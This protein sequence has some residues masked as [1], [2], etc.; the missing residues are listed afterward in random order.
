MITFFCRFTLVSRALTRLC[1]NYGSGTQGTI[2][3]NTEPTAVAPDL[4]GYV[5]YQRVGHTGVAFSIR[6]YRARFC[7]NDKNGKRHTQQAESGAIRFLKIAEAFNRMAASHVHTR[8]PI[9]IPMINWRSVRSSVSTRIAFTIL[10]SFRM[11][12]R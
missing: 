12:C 2:R 11:R 8:L 9:C 10:A 4:R 5:E 3:S 6:R 7:V 1:D